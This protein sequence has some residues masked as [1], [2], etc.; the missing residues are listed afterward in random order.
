MSVDNLLRKR[1]VHVETMRDNLRHVFLLLNE[2]ACYHL[3]DPPTCPHESRT[4]YSNLKCYAYA[5]CVGYRDDK[6]PGM[7][8]SYLIKWFK[9]SSA[10]CESQHFSKSLLRK[11][12][13]FDDMM[14]LLIFWNKNQYV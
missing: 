1:H 5:Y 7:P 4:N 11:L 3:P 8:F 14:K 12:K 6:L 10:N 9:K 2:S 13:R